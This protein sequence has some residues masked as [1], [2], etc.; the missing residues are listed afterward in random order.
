[1]KYSIG[2]YNI[3]TV[4]LAVFLLPAILNTAC[5]YP[6]VSLRIETDEKKRKVVKFIYPTPK[7]YSWQAVQGEKSYG[8]LFEFVDYT[9]ISFPPPGA[10]IDNRKFIYAAVFDSE[11][12]PVTGEPLCLVSEKRKGYVLQGPV[13]GIF[14]LKKGF[15]VIYL[16]ENAFHYA[17]LKTDGTLKKKPEKFYTPREASGFK[18][19]V[20]G[21]NFHKDTIY[22]FILTNPE[23][24]YRDTWSFNL[25]KRDITRGSTDY[26]K[27]FIASKENLFHAKDLQVY[28]SG[29]TMHLAWINGREI[30]DNPKSNT[31]GLLPEVYLASCS[32]DADACGEIFMVFKGKN[33]N[34][35]SLRFQDNSDGEVPV[36]VIKE[37][38]SYFIHNP[39]LKAVVT[40]G[41][42]S[43]YQHL[44]RRGGRLPF[45]VSCGPGR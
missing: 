1:M 30:R 45:G 4:I 29:S 22:L 31:Y 42:S 24:M 9:Q 14:P 34:R 35:A 2:I 12:N 15:V 40:A 6:S 13:S 43:E 3:K 38:D 20:L 7:M 41:S 44:F 5:T 28:F 11:L 27:K 10:I 26:I 23:N 19:R 8:I 17:I 16:S 36:L 37:N 33:Y 32:T 39:A 21:I 18:N 25:V